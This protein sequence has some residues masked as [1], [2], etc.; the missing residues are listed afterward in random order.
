MVR[1]ILPALYILLGVS[2]PVVLA[3]SVI[4]LILELT[5]WGRRDEALTLVNIAVAGLIQF[6]LGLVLELAIIPILDSVLRLRRINQPLAYITPIAASVLIAYILINPYTAL[7]LAVPL[8]YILLAMAISLVKL[9]LVRFTAT[10]DGELRTVAGTPLQYRLRVIIRPRVNAEASIE[11]PGGIR[12][13][14]VTWGSGELRLGLTA[15]FELGGVYRPLIRVQL[16]D[17]RG[18][19]KVIKVIRHPPIIVTPR[20][21]QAL[22]LAEGV[23]A[24]A[25]VYGVGDISD[26]REYEPGD[27]IRRIHWKKTA[28]LGKPVVKLLNEPY[29]PGDVLAFSYATNAVKLDKLGSLIVATVTQALLSGEY[30]NVALVNRSGELMFF[31]VTQGNFNETMRLILTNLENIN[32]SILGG[33]D[34]VG[35]LTVMHNALISRLTQATSGLRS[36]V[37]VGDGDLINWVCLRLRDFKCLLT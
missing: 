28:Q 34:Y 25:S 11:A 31:K 17:V 18:L 1:K 15:L 6:P 26:L 3:S 36:P 2:N 13:S 37:I 19:V 5:H 22:E 29:A 7:Q 12:V 27:P 35:Y 16:R 32:A 30:V 20:T 4:L 33:G 24:R 23:L 9:S 8:I 21:Q 10:T 14:E